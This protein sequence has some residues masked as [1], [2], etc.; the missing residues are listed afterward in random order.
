VPFE[1]RPADKPLT[2]AS[3]DAGGGLT[4]YVDPVAVGDALPDAAL[5]LSPGWYVTT[6]LEQ[7]YQASWDV[8]P[9]AIRELLGTPQSGDQ[10]RT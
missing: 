9:R 3:Y 4:T 5:F 1:P 8:T 10:L 2:V 6:P 7:T